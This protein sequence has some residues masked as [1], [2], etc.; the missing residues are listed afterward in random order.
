M[1]EREQNHG[2]RDAYVDSCKMVFSQTGAMKL[3]QGVPNLHSFGDN[4]ASLWLSVKL[5]INK[6]LT[7]EN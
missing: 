2:P 5:K 1:L 7:T 4:K 3:I 6:I